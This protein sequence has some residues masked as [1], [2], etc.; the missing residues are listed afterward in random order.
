MSA[1]P[2]ELSDQGR[3]IYAPDQHGSLQNGTGPLTQLI[4]L[5][6]ARPTSTFRGG[7]SGFGLEMDEVFAA[8][9]PISAVVTSD[10]PSH[11]V[12]AVVIDAATGRAVIESR[13]EADGDGM[14]RAEWPPLPPGRLPTDRLGDRSGQRP[15]AGA[16]GVHR[17]RT[18][19][20]IRVTARHDRRACCSQRGRAWS[21]RLDMT[22]ARIGDL[23]SRR[24]MPA[25]HQRP[26]HP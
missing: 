11:A 23:A 16:L 25:G 21:E 20:P 6:S 18:A 3:E 26:R 12:I 5:L 24:G 17:R 1:T 10:D 19:R 7:L 13:E 22:A 9:E 14:Y 8:D 2:V 4:G 15:G